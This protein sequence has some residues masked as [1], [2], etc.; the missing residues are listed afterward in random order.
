MKK[1]VIAGILL[2]I[3]LFIVSSSLAG[4]LEDTINVISKAEYVGSDRCLACHEQLYFNWLTT[5]HPYKVRPANENTIVGDFLKNNTFTAKDIKGANGLTEYKTK[6][7][8]KDGK[9]YITTIGPDSKEHTYPV[10]YVLGGAW[11]Q[12]YMT[13]FNNGAI[14]ILPV[15]WN[16]FTREWVDYQGLKTAPPGS[17]KYWSDKNRTWQFQCGSCHVTGLKINYD[18]EKNTFKTKWSDSGAA[19]EACH[20][21]GSIHVAEVKYKKT[22]T[23][24]NPA[25]IPYADRGAQVC[26]QCHN[27]GA[28]IAET[29]APIGPKNYE[30]PNGEARYIP[31]KVL[32]NYYIEKPG[33]WPDGSS[34]QHHQ[35]YNDW[36]KSKHA[37]AGIN[38]W[39]CHSVH[40][41]GAISKH[42][43]KE[44]GDKLCLTCHQVNN[45]LTHSL[46]SYNGCLSCHM[47]K[48]AMTATKTGAARYDISSHT[49]KVIS[50]AETIKYGGLDKQ[51]N[52]CNAC[53]YHEKD[54]PEELLKVIESVRNKKRE[55]LGLE[56]KSIPTTVEK[57]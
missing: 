24:L 46:H 32:E 29:K 16:V 56:K 15:Q 54:K 57:K 31:G 44:G 37:D 28:S 22:A 52:S 20:G 4:Y 11:K 14:H 6:M 2:L 10:K 53:H 9:Y 27:R 47:P 25:K 17:G 18:A 41:K 26:G 23:I 21:P 40:G 3:V 30:F 39:N 1:I 36:K 5:L 55:S 12:R 7:T 48:T 19:C 50:P 35:Q 45:E 13:E 38:C 51:P 42:S 43:I 49:F 34:K 8:K 33:L